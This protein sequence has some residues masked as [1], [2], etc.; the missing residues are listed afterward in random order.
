MAGT[1]TFSKVGEIKVVLKDGVAVKGV[2]SVYSNVF[3]DT[4]TDSIII[5]NDASRY[6]S[7]NS[8]INGTKVAVSDVLF[9]ICADKTALAN[10]LSLNYFN[11]SSD[12]DGGNA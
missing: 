9:P 12:I 11:Q 3:E 6:S 4:L 10:E 7:M 2:F 8:R 5:T 1:L